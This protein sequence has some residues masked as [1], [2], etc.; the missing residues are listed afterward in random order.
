M[1]PS[2]EGTR[3]VASAEPDHVT[4][5]DTPPSRTIA[6]TRPRVPE[7]RADS[8]ARGTLWCRANERMIRDRCSNRK[9]QIL[10]WRDATLELTRHAWSIEI[11]CSRLEVD[12]C[13][14]RTPR[15]KSFSA[16]RALI[17]RI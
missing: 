10:S 7:V 8:E 3:A 5:Q 4:V 9:D 15:Q 16:I 6:R 14:P 17:Q 1:T 12:E 11:G 2:S 13:L